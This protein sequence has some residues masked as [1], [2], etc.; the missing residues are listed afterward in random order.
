MS[1]H[2]AATSAAR[3]SKAAIFLVAGASLLLAACIYYPIRFGALR[4]VIVALALGVWIG[5]FALLLKQNAA[6][7]VFTVLSAGAVLLFLLP[8]QNGN[9]HALRERYVS[10]LHSLVN[11]P[12]VWGGETRRGLD[13][14]GLL[15][16]ALWQANWNE[17]VRTGNPKLLREAAAL[18]W[19]DASARELG[20][21]YRGRLEIVGEAESLNRAN[22]Q[23]LQPGDIAVTS[24]DGVHCLAY[25]GNKTWIEADPSALVGDKVIAVQTPVQ[26]AW[27]TRRVKL[28][29]WKQL[30]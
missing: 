3:E 24:P 15:R 10:T 1:T 22:Y 17:G 12:Y 16:Y 13:C 21:T 19:N 23:I 20:E 30:M 6:R 9:A 18:W 5:I 27:F 8:G 29:R 2:K 14:S 4:A 26:N 25:V 11:T 28:L 7:Q